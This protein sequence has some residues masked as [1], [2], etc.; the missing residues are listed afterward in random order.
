[1]DNIFHMENR[2]RLFDK[3]Q[4]GSVVIMFAGS[5][6]HK[7]ADEYY[8]FSADRNFYYLTGID[9]Q[10]IILVLLKR[11]E[12]NEEYIFVEEPDPIAEKW[13]GRKLTAQQAA[14]RSGVTNIEYK[15]DFEDFVNDMLNTNKYKNIYFDFDRESYRDSASNAEIFSEEIKKKYPY[16]NIKNIYPAICE[17]RMVKSQDEI[18]MMRKAI[19]ITARGIRSMLVNMKPGMTEY[20]IEAYFNYELNKNGINQVAFKTIAAS[21][22][23][24]TV[25]HYSS[26]MSKTNEN[27]MI[28]FD[29]GASY[30]YYNADISRTFP[31]NGRYT[32]RQRTIYDIV[33]DA[34]KKTIAAVKPGIPYR[35]LNN[36][37]K[38]F[39][40]KELKRIGLIE[41][42]SDVL[43]YYFHSVS[44]FL[45][46]DTHDVG[47]YDVKLEPGMVI[48]MEPGLYISNEGI[49]IRIEDDVLVTDSGCEVLSDYIIKDPD[50]IEQFMRNR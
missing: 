29:L 35:E 13:T 18:S 36:V 32:K 38:N 19:E 40:A 34:Q 5:A 11:N 6:P 7:S 16:I 20:Q 10:N 15:K 31:V 45:G 50:E 37:T 33:L 27:D 2:E 28:L 9:S 22:K 17:L 41:N 48:T 49:G 3:I 21:G 4:D 47:F 30:H 42:D 43:E 25:L 23:N 12:R 14:D 46:L 39:Y 24:A 26:N 1:M 8:E 44:H